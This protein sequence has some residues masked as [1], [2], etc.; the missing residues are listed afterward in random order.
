MTVGASGVPYWEDL[1][2]DEPKFVPGEEV[3]VIGF[4]EAGYNSDRVQVS[5]V[6]WSNSHDWKGWFYGTEHVPVEYAFSEPSLVK[7]NR[8]TVTTW[9]KVAWAPMETK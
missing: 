5:R 4:K 9:D 8:N 2:Q 7:L 6:L 1:I 3:Q